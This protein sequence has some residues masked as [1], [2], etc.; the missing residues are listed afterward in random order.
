MSAKQIILA[1]VEG[2]ENPTTK[3]SMGTF[4]YSHRNI[5]FG[6][7]ATNTICCI[8]KISNEELLSFFKTQK[9]NLTGLINYPFKNKN[10]ETVKFIGGFEYAIDY[11]RQGYVTLYNQVAKELE[12]AT[13]DFKDFPLPLLGKKFNSK[14]LDIF[15][16]LANEQ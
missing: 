4:G 8:E 3:I 5:C 10:L 9:E 14:E 15:K 13:I 12:I 2:L 1:M 16:K 6:C 7:A 11:L